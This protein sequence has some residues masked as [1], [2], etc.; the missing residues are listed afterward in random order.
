MKAQ[1]ALYTLAVGLAA[2]VLTGA[3][4]AQQQL[5]QKLEYDLISPQ[6][7]AT[8]ERIEVIEFFW[9]GC[10]HCANLQPPLEGWLKRKPADVELRRVPAVFR[11]TWIPH[12]RLF[13]TLETLGEVG[14]LHQAVYRAIHVEKDELRTPE[15]TSAWA[16]RNGIEPT[17]WLT[18]YNS[19]EVERKVQE[20]R[21]HTIAY[22]I[23]GTPSL[24]VDGRYL[25]SSGKAESMPQVITILEGLIVMARDRR[26]K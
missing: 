8:G 23:D 14:R 19:P 10:P 22:A 25:T 18:A 6:P 2:L 12:A 15:A 9:Y 5:R 4:P 7:T 24:V 13:Y 26:A 21:K 1:R 11:D 16:S 20:S 3:A 17:R